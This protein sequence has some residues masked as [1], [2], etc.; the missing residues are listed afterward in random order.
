MSPQIGGFPGA[1]GGG[2][3]IDIPIGGGGVGGVVSPGQAVPFASLRD[4]LA[5][6][7]GAANLIRF[8]LGVRG[9]L[10]NFARRKL[11]RLHD[12]RYNEV[13][14]RLDTVEG[15]AA[16]PVPTL[17]SHPYTLT[18]TTGGQFV[19][20]DYLDPQAFDRAF[21]DPTLVG[22]PSAYTLWSSY[23][24][25]GPM[26]D[27]VIAITRNY[28]VV[29]PSLS[30]DEDEDAFSQNWW[31]LILFTALVEA[32]KYLV[33]DPRAPMWQSMAKDLEM[34]LVIEQRRARTSG[35]RPVGREPS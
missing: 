15:V 21:P 1:G 5:D 16:Y 17:W 2:G 19:E 22:I 26:P 6:W 23:L 20:L 7:L 28:Y 9:D 35:R 24:V 27:R 34:D 13:T 12:T 10:I 31:E 8:P 32:S 11:S 14:D 33:E 3:Q 30:A 18:H 29:L 25:L 4:R